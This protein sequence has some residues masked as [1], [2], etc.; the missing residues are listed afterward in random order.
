[1]AKIIWA[2][3]T[4]FA[5]CLTDLGHEVIYIKYTAGS[6]LRWDDLPAACR[7]A[8][9]DLFVL[10]DVSAPPFILGV[11]AFPCLTAFYCVDSHLHSWY[12]RYA[13]AFDFCLV[14]LKDHLPLFSSA[15]GMRLPQDRVVWCPPYAIRKITETEQTCASP[16]KWDILFVG[17]VEPQVNPERVFFLQKLKQ[18][19]PS[20]DWQSGD[21]KKFFPK[22]KLILNHCIAGDLNF[23][24]ME[25]LACGSCLLTPNIGHGLQE[26]FTDREDLFIYNPEDLPALGELVHKLLQNPALCAKVAAGGLKKVNAGHLGAHRAL[27]L[28]GILQKHMQG[29]NAAQIVQNRL[30]RKAA[31][32]AQYLKLI[33]LLFAESMEFP[34]LRQAYLVAA[35]A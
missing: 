8:A 29:N 17:K 13:Q 16:K 10:G 6:V 19:I 4:F 30:V 7:S 1:M 26:L 22:A 31:I 11:E 18:I 9:P 14:S 2:G 34:A 23:R 5:P 15:T 32:H 12:P 33:Y 20:L 21:F 28:D 25:A 35:K 3:N 27:L 24:I